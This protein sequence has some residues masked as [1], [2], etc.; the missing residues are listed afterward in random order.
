MDG[1][2]LF[3]SNERDY[4]TTL[5]QAAK[6]GNKWAQKRLQKEFHL[7]LADKKTLAHLNQELA[8]GKLNTARHWL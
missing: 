6:V 4:S 7:K 5:L 3:R 2:P 8:Q 1:M